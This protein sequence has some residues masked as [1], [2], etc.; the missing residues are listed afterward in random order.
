[1]ESSSKLKAPRF[2]VFIFPTFHICHIHKSL[3]VA[4]NSPDSP[5]C[6]VCDPTMWA[7]AL[8]MTEAGLV[9]H[10]PHPTPTESYPEDPASEAAS[11]QGSGQGN[12]MLEATQ[13]DTFDCHHVTLGASAFF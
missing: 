10:W 12:D 7:L 2:T 1:M 8:R 9:S 13:R 6:D 3:R 5:V 4:P 11:F